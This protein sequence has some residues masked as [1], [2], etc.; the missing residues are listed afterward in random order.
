MKLRTRLQKLLCQHS[1]GAHDLL[2][3]IENEKQAFASQKCYKRFQRGLARLFS[4]AQSRGHGRRNE[5]GIQNGSHVDKPHAVGEMIHHLGG[6]LEC[7]T[8]FAVAAGA[9]ERKQ[10]C[11]RNQV[12]DL[13]YLCLAPDKAGQLPRQV[14]SKGAQR[15]Q[16][17]EVFTQSAFNV[18]EDV[19]GTDKITQAMLAE[20]DQFRG[21][22][23]SRPEQIDDR[24]RQNDL[25]SVRGC[26]YAGEAIERRAKIVPVARFCWSRVNGDADSQGLADLCP[27]LR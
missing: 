4:Q 16:Q 22:S 18:L 26:E 2:A 17:R 27:G 23:Q 7:Q 25:S 1:A 21:S 20:I 8:C 12:L 14:V 5:R 24:F 9:R 15:P 19:L 3:I 6:C 11:A 13:S 10:T